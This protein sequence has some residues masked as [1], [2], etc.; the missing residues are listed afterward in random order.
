[1]RGESDYLDIMQ[2]SLVVT[3]VLIWVSQCAP[4]HWTQKV[5]PQL[6]RLVN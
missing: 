3:P 2:L 6:L 1:M 5:W 4:Q